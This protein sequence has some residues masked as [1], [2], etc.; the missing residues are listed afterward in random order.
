M[1]KRKVHYRELL[2]QHLNILKSLQYPSGLFGAS[3][4]KVKTGYDKSWLR[5]N[6]YECLAFEV[7]ED[8]Q[9]A[10]Q[11][12]SALLKVFLKHEYKIDAAIANKPKFKHEYIHARVHPMTFDEF[13]EDWG[14][15]QND[16]IGAILFG[17][18]KLEKIRPSMLLRTEDD[19]RIVNKL[20]K[21]LNSLEYWHDRDSGMWEENEEVHMSSVGACV[22]G[23]D[24]ISKINGIV[25][26][27][28]LIEKGKA[29]LNK[30][31]PRESKT[32]FVDLAELSLIWPYNVV[33]KKQKKEILKNVEYHLLKDRGIVRYKGDYYY[34]NN[35]DGHSE[36]AEWT[37]GLAWLAIIYEKDGDF[38]K[39]RKFVQRLKEL[40]TKKGLP[41]LYFSNS[42][43]F[44]SNT[45]LGWTESL[46]IISLYNLHEKHKPKTFMHNLI[47]KLHT[48]FIRKS[49]K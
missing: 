45:P 38:K 15:K 12:Y 39:A 24:A 35:K 47:K 8:Y 41:E 49:K 36:E 6:F 4:T 20:I 46:F 11:T 34:N 5:D 48:K 13:W 18:A 26:S 28:E 2:E 10:K 30:R 17:I 29:K 22:A 37:F 1:L 7:I 44:N 9:T 19:F 23:L 21:Y 33:S 3:S 32:K 16:A 43:K 27:K 14:N 42:K 40:D 31:L 25:V